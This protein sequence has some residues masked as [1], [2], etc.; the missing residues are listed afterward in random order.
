MFCARTSPTTSCCKAAY[1]DAAAGFLDIRRLGDMLKRIKGRITHM[2]LDRISPLSVPIM[3]EIGRERIGG[4][5][6]EE[7]LRE[8]SAQYERNQGSV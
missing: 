5:A 8:M 4:E 7:I 1:T 2:P 6:E 3:L